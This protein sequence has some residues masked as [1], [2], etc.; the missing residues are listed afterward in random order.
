MLSTLEP[1]SAYNAFN[2][3]LVS[4]L[5]PLQLGL[6]APAAEGPGLAE[7]LAGDL[8]LV[9]LSSAIRTLNIS[10]AVG[11]LPALPAPAEEAPGA[12][13]AEAPAVV[14]KNTAAGKPSRKRAALT[15]KQQR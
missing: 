1:E 2:L 15:A 11:A 14:A 6:A 8:K 4:E 3:N 9:L 5:A 12:E 13:E 7:P 10:E